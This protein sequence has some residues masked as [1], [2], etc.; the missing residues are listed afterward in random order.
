MTTRDTT[1]RESYLAGRKAER[2]YLV[3]QAEQASSEELED[4]EK[5]ASQ[6]LQF[7]AT[8]IGNRPQEEPER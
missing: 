6:I 4:G 1:M 7:I 5:V 3:R 8:W 2:E